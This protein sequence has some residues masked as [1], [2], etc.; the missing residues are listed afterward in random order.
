MRFSIRSASRLGA[1][2]VWA[3]LLLATTPGMAGKP[4]NPG[5]DHGQQNFNSNKKPADDHQGGAFP[6]RSAT[7]DITNGGSVLDVATGSVPDVV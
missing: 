6:R 1:V 7:I 2:L 3:A 5:N 4:D